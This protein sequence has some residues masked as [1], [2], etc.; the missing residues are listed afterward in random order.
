MKEKNYNF[1][2]LK[3]YKQVRKYIIVKEMKE[4]LFE[5]IIRGLI[6]R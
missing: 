2:I 1:E 3:N 5:K 6:G 4:R